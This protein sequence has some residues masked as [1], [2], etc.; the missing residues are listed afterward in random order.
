M[1][2]WWRRGGPRTLPVPGSSGHGTVVRA[3]AP[4]KRLGVGR[5]DKA[6]WRDGDEV[7]RSSPTVLR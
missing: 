6:K 1:S 7:A 5:Y 4:L 2:S 3:A